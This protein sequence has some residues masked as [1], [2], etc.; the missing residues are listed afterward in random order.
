MKKLFFSLMVLCLTVSCMAKDKNTGGSGYAKA[1]DFN[2]SDLS[3]K[4]VKLKS[5]KGKKVVLLVFGATWCPYCV[6]EVPELNELHEKMDKKK[7]EILAVDIQES[8]EHVS[9]FVK[10]KGIK[11][12]ML[13]DTDASAATAYGVRGIPMSFLIDKKGYIKNAG[14]R[15]PSAEEIKKLLK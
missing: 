4:S 13:M 14:N 2:L 8:Y 12:R 7:F 3:G 15:L 9:K 5:Y 10:A 6:K 11:Y 1:P